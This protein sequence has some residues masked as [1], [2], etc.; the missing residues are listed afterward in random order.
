LRRALLG[1]YFWVF[2]LYTLFL[3]LLSFFLF[4]PL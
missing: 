1:R 4:F 3:S 2:S